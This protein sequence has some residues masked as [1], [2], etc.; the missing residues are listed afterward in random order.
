MKKPNLHHL[1]TA[2]LL[3]MTAAQGCFAAQKVLIIMETYMAYGIVNGHLNDGLYRQLTIENK[4]Y[5]EIFWFPQYY[6]TN[7]ELCTPLLQRLQ[8]EYVVARDSGDTLEGAILIGNIPVP[9][10]VSGDYYPL[11]QVFMDIVDVNGQP[12]STAP[13]TPYDTTGGNGYYTTNYKQATGDQHY[14]IWISRI[15]AS[16]LA[17]GIRQGSELIDENTVIYNYLSRLNNRMNAPETVPSRGFAMGGCLGGW[18]SLDGVHGNMRNLSLPWFAEFANGEASPFNW[19]SQLMGGPYGTINYGGF[20]GSLYPSERN[21]RYCRYTQLPVYENGSGTT[22]L[23]TTTNDS[24][25]WEWAGLYGHSDPEKTDFLKNAYLDGYGNSTIN[26]EFFSQSYGMLWGD[27]S[28][29]KKTDPGYYNGSAHYFNNNQ[30]GGTALKCAEWRWPD[31]EVTQKTF[32]VYLSYISLPTNTPCVAILLWILDLDLTGVPCAV[33][34]GF[35]GV[36]V[37]QTKHVDRNNWERVIQNVT[38]GPHQMAR[39]VMFANWANGDVIADAVWFHSTSPDTN[40]N[41]FVDDDQPSSYPDSNNHPTGIFSTKGFYTTDYID[42]AY[43]EM[44]DE[45]GG[46]G[47]SKTRFFVTYSCSMNNWTY[48]WTDSGLIKPKNCGTL[49]ALGHNGLICMGGSTED[50]ADADK[51]AYINALAAG[52][53]FGQA[54][55]EQSNSCWGWGTCWDPKINYAL[56]GAGTLRAQPYVQFGSASYC[57]MNIST[58]DTINTVNPVLLCNDTVTSTGDFQVTST[59]SSSSPFGTHAEVVIQPETWFQTGSSVDIK[60]Q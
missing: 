37:D 31:T 46:N 45:P 60:A 18:P 15:N 58:H 28:I 59:H 50:Y 8:Q 48:S 14:D 44:G 30:A 39:L 12:Y 32:D 20:N 35:S 11:D 47:L 19:V 40:T 23:V 5:S 56:L 21:R 55:L 34:T 54:Y 51:N 1:I 13:Y 17:G 49:Y 9:M 22:T 33:N 41:M 16:Y 42:R 29:W 27:S 3:I 4:K 26:G 24:L 36:F 38:L 53:D 10:Y 6:G 52:S 2:L 25:G 7:V 43:E 57:G